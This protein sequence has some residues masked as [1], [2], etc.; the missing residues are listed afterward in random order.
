M[1]AV[2]AATLA[3]SQSTKMKCSIY[4]HA[5]SERTID[6]VSMLCTANNSGAQRAGFTEPATQIDEV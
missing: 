2:I 1:Y 6:Y 4:M 3:A 5:V